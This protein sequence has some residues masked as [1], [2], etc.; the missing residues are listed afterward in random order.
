MSARCPLE[1][2]RIAAAGEH[3]WVRRADPRLREHGA[4]GAVR[5]GA[6]G[7]GRKAPASE[8]DG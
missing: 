6:L 3:G 2:G 8:G 4:G 5:T 7:G 1:G